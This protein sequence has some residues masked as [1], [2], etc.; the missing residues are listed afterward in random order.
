[1]R[2][3]ESSECSGLDPCPACTRIR[4][5]VLIN[6]VRGAELT[7]EQAEKFFR[8]YAESFQGAMDQVRKL[9]EEA[10]KKRLEEKAARDKAVK[11]PF[12]SEAV[13]RGAQVT[14]LKERLT[15][16]EKLHRNNAYGKGTNGTNGDDKA[17]AAEVA[18]S[19]TA[20]TPTSKE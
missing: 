15:T 20:A 18:G 17:K 10:G 3:C 8:A 4:Q 12:N 19:E 2:F 1:M 6:A 13:Q 14:P 7:K 9:A 16:R 11:K 5:A